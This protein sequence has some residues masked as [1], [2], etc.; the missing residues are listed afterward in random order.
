MIAN[1]WDLT[2]K[3]A[4]CLKSFILTNIVIKQNEMM[5]AARD[6]HST[7]SESGE[8]D[9]NGEMVEM[10]KNSFRIQS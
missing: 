10:G 8:I 1:V 9:F 4:V 5:L 3:K 6:V 7:L 2:A